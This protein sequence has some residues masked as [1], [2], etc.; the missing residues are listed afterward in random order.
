M[1]LNLITTNVER[2][3]IDIQHKNKAMKAAFA[4]VY[5]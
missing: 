2:Q 4:P 5:T 1:S 3:I